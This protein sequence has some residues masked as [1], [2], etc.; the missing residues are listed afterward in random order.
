MLHESRP[1]EPM[2][3]TQSAAEAEEQAVFPNVVY[4]SLDESHKP[5]YFPEP[6]PDTVARAHGIWCLKSTGK[7]GQRE[8]E[9]QIL[10]IFA[11]SADK[12]SVMHLNRQFAAHRV[13]YVDSPDDLLIPTFRQWP[14]PHQILFELERMP[15]PTTPEWSGLHLFYF[16]LRNKLLS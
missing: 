6:R 9:F 11:V 4:V 10:H 14:L 8:P 13:S 3:S 2:A 1:A 15:D 5:L 12:R 16:W 7:N